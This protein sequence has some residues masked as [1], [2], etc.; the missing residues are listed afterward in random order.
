MVKPSL[1]EIKSL[2][3]SYSIVPVCS[4]IFSDTRTP[5]MILNSLR[6]VSNRCYMLESV[7][8]GDKWGRY[9]FLGFDPVMQVSCKDN[10]INIINGSIESFYSENPFDKLKKLLSQY[11]S[12]SFEFM[13]PFTGGFVGYI[14]YDSIKYVEKRLE[15]KSEDKA[16]FNDFELMLYDKVIAFDHY[17]Q[18]IFI[19][20]NIKTDDLE[21]NY[22]KAEREIA[23][24][25]DIVKGG[26]GASAENQK[27]EILED[28][29]STGG[30]EEYIQAVNKA[31][32]H[33]KDGD[34][35]Q[36]VL[37]RRFEGKIKGD[38][39]NPY[40]I[41][42]TI[43]PS[44][45]M[46]F[47]DTG[48]VQ[49]AGA[50][51]ETLVKLDK[52]TVTTFPIAGTRKRGRN[53]AEDDVLEK[54]LLKDEKELSE[55]NM[56]VDLG[57]NDIGK[58]SKFGSVKVTDYE[59]ILKFSHVMHIASTVTGEIREDVDAVDAV[60]AI[61]PA[62]T[63]SGAPKIR[64]CEL[65]DELE[66]ERRG[67]YG[68]AIGYMDFSGNMDMCI[69]IRMI[70]KKGLSVYVQSGAGIVAD[71]IPENEFN[72]CENKAGAMFEAIYRAKED[73]D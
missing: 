30:K 67:I 13:P 14:G 28:F 8:G 1:T 22:E 47:M 49:I 29:Q 5:I 38:L 15:F 62:G 7:E 48:N 18:K 10:T 25:I 33:I 17:K 40:R 43:N 68:G 46:F 71:S 4:E 16:C 73:I 41:L 70:I 59:K 65:I 2:T 45:Y 64:A 3:E 36:A 55:H 63:L 27:I 24:L 23:K 72:E 20:V 9:S 6:K 34:I 56:L 54:E 69:A 60:K 37:S 53:D 66:S 52:N 11:K 21:G 57:R 39:L 61:L 31:V 51:P 12:P 32:S 19:I 26:S 58:I 42:R 44:P 50:S 35:F